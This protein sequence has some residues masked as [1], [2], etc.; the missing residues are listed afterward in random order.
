MIDSAPG[1]LKAGRGEEFVRD[2]LDFILM[3][4]T[5]MKQKVGG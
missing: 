1:E 2:L 5:P 3:V 4:I